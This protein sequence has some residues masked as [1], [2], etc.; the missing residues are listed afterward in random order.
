MVGKRGNL[1]EFIVKTDVTVL[2]ALK[3]IDSN[4]KGFVVVIN[5]NG[6]VRGVLTDGDIRRA[7]INGKT[8]RESIKDIYKA[9]FT[10]L[11]VTD[12]FSKAIDIFK[13]IRIK[14]L[15]IIAENDILVNIITKRQMHSL[16]LQD[17]HADLTFDFTSLDESIVDTEIFQRPWGFYKTTVLNDYYQAKV[18]S[19]RPGGQLS[20]QSHNHRE[21]HWI[22]V[23]GTGLVQIDDS[24]V[25]VHTGS[26]VFLPKGC[27]HRLKNTGNTEN[28]II[29]EIQI[30]DYLGEDDIIRYEDVYGRV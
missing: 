23:H 13:D 14:F 12:S 17:I 21:E 6:T 29:S 20:L 28:L 15:P 10:S 27:R 18:I 16:L 8:A 30:G 9:T 3:Q 22:V 7:F 24:V 11:K 26:V 1:D 2:E 19:I 4:K 5:D 25:D